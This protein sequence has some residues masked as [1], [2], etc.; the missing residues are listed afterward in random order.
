M[1]VFLDTNLF[2]TY[3]T[4]FE[5]NHDKAIELFEN[6][7]HKK[8]TG[9]RVK[10]ELNKVLKRRKKVYRDVIKSCCQNGGTQSF[11]YPRGLRKNDRLHLKQLFSQLRALM[12]VDVLTYLR[13][14]I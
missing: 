10:T 9:M 2:L 11:T 4:D 6:E 7:T 3:A 8:F 5:Q 12:H 1:R 13:E 14:K